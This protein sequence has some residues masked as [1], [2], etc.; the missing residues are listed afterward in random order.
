M[1]RI[2]QDGVE[3]EQTG[4]CDESMRVAS[5]GVR[6]ALPEV[7]ESLFAGARDCG[8]LERSCWEV[9]HSQRRLARL[10]FEPPSSTKRALIYANSPGGMKPQ[11]KT[12]GRPGNGDSPALGH[13]SILCS[14]TMTQL[15]V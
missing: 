1:R 6:P 11:L 13:S 3:A 4:T 10:S 14:D 8:L 2:E 7:T 9:R 12:F 5:L 15:G